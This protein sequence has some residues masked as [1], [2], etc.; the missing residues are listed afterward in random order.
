MYWDRV[1]AAAPSLG[2]TQSSGRETP[3]RQ[4][5]SRFL[6]GMD[7]KQVVGMEGVPQAAPAWNLW[8]NDPMEAG[9]PN[10]TSGGRRL[11]TQDSYKE[12][13]G[14]PP[15]TFQ[16]ALEAETTANAVQLDDFFKSIGVNR[17][18]RKRPPPLPPP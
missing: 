6:A 5:S 14:P 15:L 2:W 12:E 1:E 7:H 11:Y 17:K 4:L 13:A 16:Q 3:R 10:A 9:T 18:R 8:G